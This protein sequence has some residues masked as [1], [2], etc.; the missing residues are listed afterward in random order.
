MRVLLTNRKLVERAGSELYL[1]DVA[2]VLLRRGHEVMAF[3]PNVGAFGAE[4][5]DLTVAVTDDLSRLGTAP[6]VI[7]GQ[8]HLPTMAALQWFHRS[9]VVGVNHGW[10]PWSEQ[11]TIHPRVRRYVAVDEAVRDRLQFRHGLPGERIEIVPNFVDLD[12]F[13]RIGEPAAVP[14]RILLYS[15][16]VKKGSPYLRAAEGAA[17]TLGAQ[18]DVVG[19]AMG[20]VTDSPETLLGT[21]DVVLAQGRSALEAMAA[22]AAVVV[23]SSRAFGSLVTADDFDA[24]RRLNFGIRTL[25]Y[26]ATEETLL[27]QLARYDRTDAAAVTERTRSACGVDAAV[28]RLLDVYGDAIAEHETQP[29]DAEAEGRATGRFLTELT[30]ETHRAQDEAR[31]LRPLKDDKRRLTRARDKAAAGQREAVSELSA[32][33]AEAEKAAAE[34]SRAERRLA[35]LE[36]S[37]AVK[38]Q[39]AVRSRPGLTRWYRRISGLAGRLRR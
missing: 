2:Q 13:A 18:L 38:A 20:N 27:A 26:P 16:Y 4:L 37:K 39:Q 3:S 36:S 9:P 11:P 22:G 8:H 33:R 5:S 28:A 25:V 6:D 31:R 10:R 12:R 14:R 23:C 30:R 21:Y 7:H 29:V 35:S 34:L 1:R 32:A 19:S 15:N 24:M 17:A